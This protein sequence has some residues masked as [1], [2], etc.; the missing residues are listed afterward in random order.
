MDYSRRTPERRTGVTWDRESLER[1]SGPQY[2]SRTPSPGVSRTSSSVSAS[3]EPG[4]SSRDKY[5]SACPPGP[6][7]PS[8]QQT[9]SKGSA[10]FRSPS[11]QQRSNFRSPSLGPRDQQRS[12]AS[13]EPLQFFSEIVGTIEG[14]FGGLGLG[15]DKSG[16]QNAP[17]GLAKHRPPMPT[18]Q[19]DAIVTCTPRDAFIPE[20]M[21][22]AS[23][24]KPYSYFGKGDD[25]PHLG[26]PNDPS[27]ARTSS[28]AG[29]R[30]P[31]PSPARLSRV[32]LRSPPSPPPG[33][34]AS[35][36]PMPTFNKAEITGDQVL[37]LVKRAEYLEQKLKYM[38]RKPPK[39]AS[40]SEMERH[41]QGVVVA[42]EEWVQADCEAK[43]ASR[44]QADHASL[45]SRRLKVRKHEL[46]C[47]V[48]HAWHHCHDF[49]RTSVFTLA[50]VLGV[51]I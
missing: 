16:Q 18:R 36:L 50:P 22:P 10:N 3:P 29:N 4:A 43:A 32:V 5:F 30:K 6:G 20:R 15:Q 42:R 9:E 34:S 25:T 51:C 49:V 14:L 12:G 7:V 28:L 24:S 19:P 31:E 27:F 1:G 26:G 23:K 13:P 44:R 39:L 40:F 47:T 37:K 45:I 33:Q 8:P 35:A 46:Q 41:K 38:E 48:G 17:P 11:L 2:S 21:Y